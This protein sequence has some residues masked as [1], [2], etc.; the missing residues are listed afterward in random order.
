MARKPMKISRLL[1]KTIKEKITDIDGS[2]K[3]NRPVPI[4]VET[5][6]GYDYEA[7]KHIH[8]PMEYNIIEILRRGKAGTPNLSDGF[9][10]W[11]IGEITDEECQNIYDMVI[12]STE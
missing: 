9:N 11:T 10:C 4:I 5:Y 6:M 2:L 1:N 8:I 7:Q 12:E 3:L